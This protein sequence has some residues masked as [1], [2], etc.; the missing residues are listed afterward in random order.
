M[1]I[2]PHTS[3]RT[4]SNLSLLQKNE[5][6]NK[7]KTQEGSR[8]FK[9]SL[10]LSQNA[11]AV[12]IK[13]I[14]KSIGELQV[15]GKALNKIE[16]RAQHLLNNAKDNASK[17]EIQDAITHSTFRGRK[18]FDEDFGKLAKN[19]KLDSRS[20]KRQANHLDTTEEIQ[21]FNQNIK[22]QK[23]YAKQA[24]KI[25]QNDLEKTLKTDGR[26]YEKLDAKML[27]SPAFGDAHRLENLSSHKVSKLLA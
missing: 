20:L 4:P 16:G 22:A 23:E 6:E 5:R 7:T 12:R 10:T 18:V 15:L 1:K 19:I 21:K 27:K 13:E 11:S 24:V 3:S 9:D 8:N 17:K 25:L 26:D 2:T 14:N